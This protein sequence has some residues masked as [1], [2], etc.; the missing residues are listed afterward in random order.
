VPSRA[1]TPAALASLAAAAAA[2]ALAVACGGGGGGGPDVPPDDG[3]GPYGLPSRTVVTS[4]TFPL[5][6]PQAGSVV[7]VDA[8]PSLPPFSNPVF[9][10]APPDGSSRLV[11]LEKAGPI[12]VFADAPTVATTKTFLDLTSR[13]KSDTTEEGLL[14]LAFHP[15]YATN[16]R[17]FVS[18]VDLQGRVVLA[19]FQVTADP[20]VADPTETRLLAIEKP[21]S[22]HNGGMIAFGPDRMLYLSVGDGG[23]GGDPYGN[24]QNTSVLLGKVL[25][26][27]V[28]HSASGLPYGIPADN[29]FAASTGTERHEIW[30]FGLRN[31]WRFAFDR[32]SG[33]GFLAD[34][35]QDAFEE[36]DHLRRGAN[37]G[38]R[39]ME[40]NN[41]FD[42]QVSHG[43]LDAPLLDYGRRAGNCV[44]GGTVYRGTRVPALHGAFLYAD[45]GSGSLWALTYD[46]ESVTSAPRLGRV[47]DLSSFGEDAAGETILCQLGT[48]RL[49]KLSPATPSSDPPFPAHL[50]E[51]GLFADLATMRPAPGLVPYDV[52]VPLWSDGA[53]KDRYVALPG[54]ERVGWRADGAWTFPTGTALVKT[55]RLPLVAGDPSSAV[56]VET[57]VLLHSASGWEG[58]SYRWRDDESDADLLPD[59]DVRTLT[60]QDPAAPGGSV[61]R[62]W[63]F[64]GRGECLRCHTEA[65]GRVLG[66]NTREMNRTLDYAVGATVVPDNQIRA[67]AHAGLFSPN[68]PAASSLLAHPPLL[69]E[70]KPLADRA[71]A[72][73]D[74][75]CSMC[76][77]PGG[78]VGHF[79]LRASTPIAQAGLLDVPPTYGGLG[80][81]NPVLVE[82]G[83]RD[84]SVLHLRLR[85]T[86]STRMPPLA[87][88][89][90]DPDAIDVVGRWIDAGP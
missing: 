70:A 12:R 76:H 63:A 35:G 6:T 5:E 61:Q 8:F 10:A 83:D 74:V 42:S 1:S 58:Y 34:V 87:H 43:D 39:A 52:N 49:L 38:W 71:R 9:V 26:L 44:I 46:G 68:P 57:R 65:A 28:D 31:P 4:L 48:G 80:L 64:P 36:V 81:A 56:R 7:A 22:N 40:G 14:G 13:T 33:L 17:V 90:P 75:N 16:G 85:S 67:W 82:S 79:D 2:L 62:T 47:D 32:D 73:L 69:D 30:C 88:S 72:Y 41:V 53:L 60:V 45:H 55:F 89:V 66:L 84:G 19:R 77:R 11:V 86:T 54:T 37:Y 50:S 24:A 15:D 78:P 51:T 3:L 18:Y 25:R 23:Y 27:D 20:D 29:P 21:F 59:S